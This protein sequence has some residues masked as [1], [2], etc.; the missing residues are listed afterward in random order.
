[1]E[2]NGKLSMV[3]CPVLA[4]RLMPFI[5]NLQL[6]LVVVVVER[7]FDNENDQLKMKR[8]AQ[9]IFHCS[10]CII[11]CLRSRPYRPFPWAEILL[12]GYF[13]DLAALP[14]HE[15]PLACSKLIGL[16]GND[17]PG[18]GTQQF[19]APEHLGRVTL[20]HLQAFYL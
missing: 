18:N 14:Q 3:N 6:P 19:N 9:A 17:Y 8:L 5:D 2:H 16:G 13:Y 12:V 20:Q 7:A 4:N 11:N 1:M 10:L 15:Q